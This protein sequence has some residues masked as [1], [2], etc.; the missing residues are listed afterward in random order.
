MILKPSSQLLYG[1]DAGDATAPEVGVYLPVGAV[2]H[3]VDPTEETFLDVLAT[4]S[5]DD[6][7]FH[8]ARLN[9]IVSGEGDADVKSRQERAIANICAPH[10]LQSINAFAAGCAKN[11]APIVFF[12]GQLREL[13]RWAALHCRNLPGDGR[14]Y[15]D[16]E[17]RACFLKA[18]LIASDVWARRVF[19]DKLTFDGDVSLVRRRAL[20][21][22]RKGVEEAGIAPHMGIAMGRGLALF[23]DFLPSHLP[24]FGAE[25]E[26]ATGLTV[27][28]YL[29]CAM[30]MAL[31]T[32]MDRK[33]GPLFNR[34]TVAAT[35]ARSEL[36]PRFFDLVS[37][38]PA[39]MARSFWM[40]FDEAGYRALRERPVM[41]T[42]DGRGVAS[43]GNSG[44]SSF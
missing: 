34:E 9:I 3:G 12:T 8:A 4:L 5:R 39:R 23:T 22:F 1:R 15:E 29:G 28:Q 31:Y 24:Q 26:R 17:A 21:A 43:G 7:L 32:M 25:F 44:S 6:T 27:R 37:Q 42:D 18:A 11:S 20:G 10:H 33:E 38:A 36:Y 16:P 41:I 40:G 14:T 2:F 30:T 19:A 35:T 13:M